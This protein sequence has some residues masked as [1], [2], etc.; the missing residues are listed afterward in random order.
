MTDAVLV[1]TTL[2][3]PDTAAQVAKAVVGRGSVPG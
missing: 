2:P 3:S 1:L